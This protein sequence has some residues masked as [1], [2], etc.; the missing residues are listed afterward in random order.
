MGSVHQKLGT[1][2]WKRPS[3][4][5]KQ[6]SDKT[7]QTISTRGESS[8]KKYYVHGVMGWIYIDSLLL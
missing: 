4:G 3:L 2:T 7:E 8:L 6:W 1:T 5:G